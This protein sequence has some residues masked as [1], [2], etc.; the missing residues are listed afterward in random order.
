M[1]WIPAAVLALAAAC[2]APQP[3]RYEFVMPRPEV[4]ARPGPTDTS[5][6]VVYVT[7]EVNAPGRVRF[8]EGLTLVGALVDS[9]GLTALAARRVIVTRTAGG[10]RTSVFVSIDAIVDGRERDLP[11]AEGDLLFVE[12]RYI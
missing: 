7:G 1:R 3:P 12:G 10:T 2:A 4:A 9:G 8:H 5:A 11:L 6:R